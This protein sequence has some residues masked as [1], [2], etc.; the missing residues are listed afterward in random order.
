MA[1]PVQNIYYLLCYAWERLEARELLG[2]G[3][4][5]GNRVENLLGHVLNRGVSH[6]IRQGLDRGYLSFQEE[7]RRIRGKLLI[8]ETIKRTL[9]QRGKVA[10]EID[11]LSYDVPHNQVIKAAMN[12]LIELPSLDDGIRM[13]LRDHCQRM[14]QVSDVSLTPRAFRTVQLSQNLARYAF[15]VRISHLIAHCLFPDERTGRTRFHPFTA[16]ERMMGYLF[17]EFVRNFLRREQEYF[18]VEGRTVPWDAIAANE[19]DLGWLPQMRLD[20]F[21]SSPSQRVVI[22]CKY[23]ATPY[24]S[25]FGNKKLISGH[26]YQL[27]TYLSQ[28]EAT[29]GPKP[30]GLLLYADTGLGHRLS[31]ELGGYQILVRSLNLAQDWWGIRGDLLELSR[32]CQGSHPQLA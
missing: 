2:T 21:L 7:G 31:Y 10:C 13:H 23:Y 14:H 8:S 18:A 25:R 12:A 27:L 4:I 11:D 30:T 19:S 17:E 1:V 20:V 32:Q 3:S 28:L 15:L 29:E 26:L 6:L 24:Q 5:P 22:E 16:D 9:L